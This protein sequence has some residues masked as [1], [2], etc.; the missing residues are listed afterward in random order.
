MKL[1]QILFHPFVRIAGATS[2]GLGLAAIVL[3]GL[4]GAP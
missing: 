2:L 1:S 4:I 3:A